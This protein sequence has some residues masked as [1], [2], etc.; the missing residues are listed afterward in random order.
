V[1][2][3]CSKLGPARHSVRTLHCTAHSD[4]KKNRVLHRVDKVPGFF[5]SRPNR[6]SSGGGGG[7]AHSPAGEGDQSNSDERTDTVVL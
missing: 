7:G 3:P 2:V 1:P 6:D 5:S 4:D